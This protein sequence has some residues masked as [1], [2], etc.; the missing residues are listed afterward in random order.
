MS[1]DYPTALVHSTIFP[2]DSEEGQ[3]RVEIFRR[4]NTLWL[5]FVCEQLAD[6]TVNSDV[7]DTFYSVYWQALVLNAA[8]VLS[9]RANNIN[10]FWNVCHVP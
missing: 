6:R 4:T 3:E 7:I 5:L 2:D 9:A 1:R 10:M 8:V